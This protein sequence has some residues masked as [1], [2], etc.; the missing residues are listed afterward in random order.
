MNKTEQPANSVSNAKI[1][2]PTEGEEMKETKLY[3]VEVNTNFC[4]FVEVE[5]NSIE[6]AKNIAYDRA[7]EKSE[8]LAGDGCDEDMTYGIAQPEIGSVTNEDGDEIEGDDDEDE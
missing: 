3:T 7:Y 2:Q 8:E 1:Y 4:F 5:A 6:E